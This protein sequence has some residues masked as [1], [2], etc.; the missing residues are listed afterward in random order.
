MGR[1]VIRS[2]ES[3]NELGTFIEA[4]AR[5]EPHDEVPF[6][7]EAGRPL[8]AE[9]MLELARQVE[10]ETGH[11]LIFSRGEQPRAA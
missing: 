9:Q 2:F 5:D 10:R 11:R 4:G 1:E 8:T 6:R 7:D 3:L